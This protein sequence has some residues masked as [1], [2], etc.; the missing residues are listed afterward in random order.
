[1]FRCAPIWSDLPNIFKYSPNKSDV[2]QH[3]CI[4]TKHVHICPKYVACFETFSDLSKHALLSPASSEHSQSLFLHHNQLSGPSA[5]AI[6]PWQRHLLH[7]LLEAIT[8]PSYLCFSTQRR[9]PRH[10]YP[11]FSLRV[12]SPRDHSYHSSA[13]VLPVTIF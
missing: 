8:Q 12:T 7:V 10:R 3:C 13:T 9:S 4:F 2:Q 6:S 1:M 5:L 11:L